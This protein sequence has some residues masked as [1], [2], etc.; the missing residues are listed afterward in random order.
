MYQS[1][2][3]LL[4]SVCQRTASIL[5]A[6]IRTASLLLSACLRTASLFSACIRT[7]SLLSTCIRTI[8]M[9]KV[10]FCCRQLAKLRIVRGVRLYDMLYFSQSATIKLTHVFMVAGWSVTVDILIHNT[11]VY[12]VKLGPMKS[13]KEC[14]KMTS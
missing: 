13:E 12:G 8:K 5:S 7:A 4:L 3:S 10:F 2:T 6:C 11:K 9:T 1:Y 14:A